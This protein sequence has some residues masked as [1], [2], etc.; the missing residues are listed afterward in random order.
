M[1]RMPD[2]VVFPGETAVGRNLTRLRRWAARRGEQLHMD[3]PFQSWDVQ[4]LIAGLTKD[5]LIALW[6]FKKAMDGPAFATYVREVL[7]PE[8]PPGTAALPDNLATHF[9]REAMPRSRRTAAGSC[10]CRPAPRT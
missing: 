8:V 7:I 9:N 1:S 10:T 2:R 4:T 5:A 6:V 3:A